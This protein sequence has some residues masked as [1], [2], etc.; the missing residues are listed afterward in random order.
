MKKNLALLIVSLILS[1]SL[2]AQTIDQ[3]GDFSPV[4]TGSEIVYV[5]LTFADVNANG[6]YDCT[7][8]LS[9]GT[10]SSYPDY[11]VA[12]SMYDEGISFRNAT[13]FMQDVKVIPVPGQT[14]K[15]WFTLNVPGSTYS[16]D[17]V[18]TGVTIPVRLATN[19]VFRKTPVT[20]INKWSCLHNPSGESDVVTVT[21]VGTV[22]S[23]GGITTGVTN[24][25]NN[26][27]KILV[28]NKAISVTGVSS[29]EIFNLQGI[30][31]IDIINNT[32]GK[33]TS[34]KEGLYFVKAGNLIKKVIVK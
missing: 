12:V 23:V 27:L 29:Y 16:V 25:V 22:A 4:L 31:V 8:A 15:F 9:Q 20:E 33:L 17:Y 14:Y 13:T 32:E 34:L 6:N 11:S 30:K 24:N 2:K 7:F 3:S 10:I 26:N 5:E 21:T 28:R 1:F 18:T 19:Y